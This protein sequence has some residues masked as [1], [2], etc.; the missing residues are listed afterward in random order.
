MKRIGLFLFGIFICAVAIAEQI[1]INWG[2]DNQTYDTTTCEIGA[3]VALPTTPTK[4]G[5]VFRGWV[6]E[7]FDRGTFTN[8]EKVPTNSSL[9]EQDI[10]G[11]YTP[12]NGDYII[13]R[14]S[15]DYTSWFVPQIHVKTTDTSGNGAAISVEVL[16]TQE[17]FYYHYRSV[18]S[19]TRIGN[20]NFYIQYA[21]LWNI[22]ADVPMIINNTGYPTGSSYSWNYTTAVDFD[23]NA[24]VS[25][26]TW[27]FVYDGIWATNGKNGWKPD[28]QIV[29]E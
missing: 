10:H 8:W 17:I 18:L 20:T 4:R 16:D 23:V 14:D 6:A 2:V 28:Y 11:D 1:T 3:D 9:Y 5:H 29:G 7:H 12:L 19:K 22:V 24:C 21:S 13:V 27:R 26:G 25:T 15:S